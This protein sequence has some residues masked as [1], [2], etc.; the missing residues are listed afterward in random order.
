MLDREEAAMKLELNEKYDTLIQRK[1]D[2]GCYANAA[3]VVENALR[4]MNE[5][6]ERLELLRAAIAVGEAD[7]AAGRVYDWTENSMDELMREAREASRAGTPIDPDV[8]P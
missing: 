8:L 7:I 5:R 4:E 2:T 1:I 6:D 3:E